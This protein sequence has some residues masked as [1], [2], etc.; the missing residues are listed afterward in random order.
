[1]TDSSEDPQ[2]ILHP[3]AEQRKLARE[4][5]I[6]LMALQA[7]LGLVGP[8]VRGMAV[9]AGEDRVTF[10]VALTQRSAR[11][12]EDLDDLLFEFEALTWGMVRGGFALDTVVTVG[13]TGPAWSGH[14]WRR[15]FLAH[16]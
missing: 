2:S 4:N 16:M 15:I 8:D 7:S 9:E 11:S 1:M 14:P 10:H 3:D 5:S 12:D 6:V 13:D